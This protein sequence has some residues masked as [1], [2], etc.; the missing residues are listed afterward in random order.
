MIMKKIII[1]LVI[2]VSV[3]F[4]SVAQNIDPN[5]EV[6]RG[7]EGKLMDVHKPV[8]E[9]SVPDSVYRFD[10]DFDY[11]V[12]ANPY[13]GSY[14]FN[15]YTMDMKPEPC[16]FTPSRFYLDAGAGYTLHPTLDVLWSPVFKSP[17]RMDIYGTHRSYVG[18]YRI[19]HV[20]E[21][22]AGEYFRWGYD[23]MS[24]A[25]VDM[26][27]DWEKVA[28][29]FGGSYYG[30]AVDDAF[31]KGA[32]NAAD[33][34]LAVKS[35]GLGKFMYD[36]CMS[37]RYG[38]AV[39]MNE[40]LFDLAASV[41][42]LIRPYNRMVIDLGLDF[43]IYQG[44]PDASFANVWFVPRYVR[45]KGRLTTSVGLRVSVVASESP[46]FA[47]ANQYV[48][49]DIRVGYNVIKDA[50]KLYLNVTGGESVNTFAALID[51]NHH[52]NRAYSVAGM[53]VLGSS[54]ERVRPELGIDGRI[55]SFFSY[56]LH[57]GYLLKDNAAMDVIVTDGAVYRPGLG[58]GKYQQ[59]Y[60]GAEWSMDFEAFRWDAAFLY[61]HT[62]DRPQLADV[63]FVKPAGFKA[64]TSMVYNWMKRV[65]VGVD[66]E[67]VSNAR[68]IKHDVYIPYYVDLGAYA[69]YA[70][71]KKFS[72]WL[73]GGNLLDMEIQRNPLFAE[74]GVNFTAG[75]SLIF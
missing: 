16:V 57:G 25:G 18:D 36:A 75:I 14:E 31:S 4:S 61:S 53:P 35:K 54:V 56:R 2:M 15:P 38:N 48:Y 20:G 5:V 74:K 32:Y 41:G 40:H 22:E 21:K 72:V 23:L 28:L 17:F 45:E 13:K 37:Y 43:G 46:D 49:P 9:M 70:V 10:L 59:A 30:V 64:E 47:K 33:P 42:H 44:G 39:N 3:A 67:F 27:Y 71:N 29:D 26:G 34:Y 6:S 1:S 62:W 24:R 58:Y 51:K 68:T 69:E 73:R 60:A 7:Y 63:F 19:P 65:F 52:F 50:M 66:C 55:S 11:S 8:M 12:F